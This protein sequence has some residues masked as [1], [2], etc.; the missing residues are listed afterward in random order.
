M[1]RVAV[2]AFPAQ[3]GAAH[4]ECSIPPPASKKKQV[5]CVRIWGGGVKI[6]GIQAETFQRLWIDVGFLRNF[7]ESKC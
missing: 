4:T 1:N 6:L 3:P 5:L 7:R 2:R